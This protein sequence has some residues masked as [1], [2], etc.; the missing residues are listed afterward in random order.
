MGSP[1][2]IR[3]SAGVRQKG[4][5]AFRLPP[6]RLAAGAPI[7]TR[8]DAWIQLTSLQSAI[9]G[10]AQ[11]KVSANLQYEDREHGSQRVPRPAA[12]QRR[13]RVRFRGDQVGGL[14]WPQRPS[15]VPATTD[16][17][18][19]A[20]P[21][22]PGPATCSRST[23][24]CRWRSRPDLVL[25]GVQALDV[26]LQRGFSPLAER[27]CRCNTHRKTPPRCQPDRLAVIPA[28]LLKDLPRNAPDFTF[29]RRSRRR[30]PV[31]WTGTKPHP[32][33]R[34]ASSTSS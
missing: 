16:S 22:G 34:P 3:P 23:T 17:G 32:A 8:V 6:K 4:V 28:A 2:S 7:S 1:S 19:Q 14:R 27:G 9:V 24:P 11:V 31:N 33:P 12:R 18:D 29:R 21:P 25:Q 20:A 26:N 30:L 5:L 13:R 10:E 15:E